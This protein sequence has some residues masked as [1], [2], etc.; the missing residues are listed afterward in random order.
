M[1]PPS[2]SLPQGMPTR[3]AATATPRWT[4][5]AAPFLLVVLLLCSLAWIMLLTNRL[6]Q[7]GIPEPGTVANEALLP[8]SVRLPHPAIRTKGDWVTQQVGGQAFLA[9]REDGAALTIQFYGT[10][11]ALIAR[12]GPDAGRVYVTVDGSPSPQLPR[13]DTGSYLVLH[14]PRAATGEIPIATGLRPGLHIVTLTKGQ[15]TELAVSSIKVT[16]RPA[17][18]WTFVLAITALIGLLFLAVRRCW[19]VLAHASGWFL[20]SDQA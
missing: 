19:L 1:A 10:E 3:Q 6:N 12:I 2:S 14:A 8:G 18:G 20:P 16:N 11:L 5:S 17:L 13:D 9:S 15:R 7:V 4:T